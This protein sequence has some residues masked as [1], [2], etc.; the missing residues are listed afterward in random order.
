M[1]VSE[2][3]ETSLGDRRVSRELARGR[4]RP[5]AGGR[6]SD[7]RGRPRSSRFSVSYDM[8]YFYRRLYCLLLDE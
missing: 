4:F 3:E 2:W 7:G 6:R 1:V 5:D 8:H